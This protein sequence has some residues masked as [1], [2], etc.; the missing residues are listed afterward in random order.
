ME[1]VFLGIIKVTIE[2]EIKKQ[3]ISALSQPITGYLFEA[4]VLLK[5]TNEINLRPI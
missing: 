3:F 4:L 5:E 1:N 2:M